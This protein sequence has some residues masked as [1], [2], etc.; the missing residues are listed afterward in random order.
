M[1]RSSP[2]NGPAIAA[3]IAG[4]PER[5]RAVAR[6]EA[7]RDAVRR[8][9]VVAHAEREARLAINR[10]CWRVGRPWID[11]AIE[12]IQGVLEA[13]GMELHQATRVQQLRLLRRRHHCRGD[14]AG[15]QSGSIT[16]GTFALNDEALANY[17]GQ[18][19]KTSVCI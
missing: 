8:F 10:A 11:G 4:A 14:D 6:V 15:H 19:L 18:S 2:R 5:A 12:Q 1:S 3:Y 7:R 17:G 9:A 16:D 13:L